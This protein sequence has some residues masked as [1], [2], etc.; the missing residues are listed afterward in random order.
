M[1]TFQCTVQGKSIDTPKVF[2]P[3]NLWW[4]RVTRAE[5]FVKR[6]VRMQ[7]PYFSRKRKRD[8]ASLLAVALKKIGANPIGA[9]F[10][11]YLRGNIYL[12]ICATYELVWDLD[13]NARALFKVATLAEPAIDFRNESLAHCFGIDWIIERSYAWS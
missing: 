1:H 7:M 4:I 9:A 11:V 8:S 6:R 3:A 13:T 2:S 5:A 10:T 12:A